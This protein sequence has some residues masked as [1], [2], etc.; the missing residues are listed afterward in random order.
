MTNRT[1]GQSVKH[2]LRQSKACMTSGLSKMTLKENRESFK[3]T[4]NS[5]QEVA[6]ESLEQNGCTNAEIQK[7]IL[8]FRRKKGNEDFRSADLMEIILNLR[9]EQH[10][11]DTD[12]ENDA[13]DHEENSEP[14]LSKNIPGKNSYFCFKCTRPAFAAIICDE[15]KASV[16]ANQRQYNNV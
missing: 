12:D 4:L 14:R 8:I 10:V 2:T 5:N 1:T 9:E 11:S 3:E 16:I 6:V 15:C 7:S 13:K